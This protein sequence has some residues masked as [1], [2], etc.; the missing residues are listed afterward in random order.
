VLALTVLAAALRLVTLDLQSVWLDESA[1]IVLVRRGLGGMLSHLS[2]SESTPPLYYVLVWGWTKVFGAG[3]I[4][5]RSFSALVGTLTVPVMYLAGRRFS[6][7]VGLWAAALTT[8]NPAMYYY[9]QESRCYALLILFSA[10]AFVFWARALHT[11]DSRALGWWAAM[12]ILALLTHYFAVFLFIP[13]AAMLLRSLGLRAVRVPIGAIVVAGLALLPLALTERASGQAGWIEA[14]SLLSRAAEAPKQYLVG[15]YGPQ[16]ILSALL[17][18]LLAAGALA[19]VVF[20]A[21]ARARQLAREIAIVAAVAL[22]VPLALAV[23]HIFDVFDGRNVIAVWVPCAV[24][25]AIGIAS[26]RSPRVGAAVGVG[27]CLVS[28]LVIVGIDTKPGYQRDD[29]R[30]VADRLP[31]HASGSV[32]VTPGN[33]L[34]PLSIY[35]ASIEKTNSTSVSTREI[36]FVALRVKHTGRA[37]SAAVVPTSPPAGFQPAGVE[38]TESY[39]IARFVASRPINTSTSA[40]HRMTSESASEVLIRH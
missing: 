16:E 34:L 27:M 4:G 33:G 7:R 29:W 26:T 25:V 28:L 39:A 13:E 10:A 23:S 1:T 17:A 37:P 32:V 5:F 14:T 3:V 19:L 36:D 6:P 12:S 30:A 15:L 40:L 11:G 22:L 18:G 31:T 24:L 35:L 2:S 9:S 8:V 20:R 21:D 38:R